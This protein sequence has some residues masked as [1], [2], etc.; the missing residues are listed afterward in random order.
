M[1]AVSN[2]TSSSLAMAG[3]AS[4]INWTNIIND[5]AAAEAAPISDWQKQQA[6]LNTENS[7]YKT[8]GTDLTNLQNDANT[9]SSASFF[10]SATTSSSD[11]S[12]ATA[13]AQAGTPFGAYS[14]SVSQLATAAVQD[15]SPVTAQPIS[16]SGDL[17]KVTLNDSAF[18]DPIT[19]GTFTVN[20]QT[21]TVATTDTLQSVFNQISTATDGAVTASYANDQITLTSNS[22][23]TLGSSADTSN[24]LQATQLY[25]NGKDSVTSLSTLAG[26]NLNVP[27]SQSNLSTAITDGGNG[28]GEFQI[29]GVTINYN[30][31]T[32]SVNQ[33][34]QAINSSEA[35]VT[36]TYDGANHRFVLTNNNTGALGMTL[37]DVTGSNFLSATGLSG[38]A[39]Q[40]GQNLSYSLNGGSPMVSESNTVDA[41]PLG[42]PGLAITAQSKGSTNI[43]VSSDT[44]TIASAIASF[45]NDY[46]TIQNYITSQTTVSSSSGLASGGSSSGTPGP[47]MGDMDAEGIATS[48]RQLVDASPLTG[49]IQNL[50]D[51]GITSNGTDNTLASNSLLVND[52]V[53]NN[54]SQISQLFSDPANGIA[55]TVSSYID[56][57]LASNGIVA[58]KEQNF[59]SQYSALTTSITNLQ[60]KISSDES[61]MQN[62]FVAM[63][64]AINNINVEKEYLTAYF[65]S[66]ATTTDAPIAA[67][68]TS[69]NS[70]GSSGSSSSSGL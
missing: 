26:I 22:P 18:A 1:S 36:A 32:E 16:S 11:S 67:S 54:L 4:G 39:F 40:P 70:S 35:G 20:G 14:F 50:N 19:A 43:T 57:T 37:T 53:T 5:M 47:L 48:L 51:L 33:I 15:G 64:D 23:I 2:S 44:S 63:E 69:S 58:S 7:A 56:N 31:S 13:S 41:T 59:T 68:S 60:S 49:V 52:A 27:A 10:E 28:Q 3:L 45:V 29:N 24:F 9:L 38:G 34:L 42:L 62:Q 55:T 46:N 12:I 17:S 65:N 25:T 66:T 6:T 21:I 61:E 30:S 8:I